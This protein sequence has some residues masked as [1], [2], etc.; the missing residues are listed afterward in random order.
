MEVAENIKQHKYNNS[1]VHEK[2]FIKG[3]IQAQGQQMFWPYR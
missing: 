2:H 1:R 3:Q